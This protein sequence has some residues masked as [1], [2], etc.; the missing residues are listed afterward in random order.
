MDE[1]KAESILIVDRLKVEKVERGD[2]IG[3]GQKYESIP[4][5]D[6]AVKYRRP[7]GPTNRRVGRRIGGLTNRLTGEVR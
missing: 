3:N 4:K 5:P 7:K 6:G 1:E 2:T